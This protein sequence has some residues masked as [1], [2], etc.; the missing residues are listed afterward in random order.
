MN[1]EQEGRQV[2]VAAMLMVGTGLLQ[3][4]GMVFLTELIARMKGWV[5]VRA[6]LQRVFS[7]MTALMLFLFV[8]H[9]TEIIGWAVVLRYVAGYPTFWLAVYNSSLA[10]TTLSTATLPPAWIYMSA[11]ESITGLVMF[12]W[13][14]SALFNAVS[15]ITTAR[16][17]YL[18][19]R[20]H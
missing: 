1:V 11:A 6:T 10:F 3:T 4:V 12:A 18:Q 9:V 15:W 13:S 2:L 14:T 5:I 19:G 7:I 20:S 16:H 8:L 17:Q